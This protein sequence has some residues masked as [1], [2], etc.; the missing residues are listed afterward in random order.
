VA[1]IEYTNFQVL[2]SKSDGDIWVVKVDIST[3][4]NND[5]IA[6]LR[7]KLYALFPEYGIR[8][9]LMAWEDFPSCLKPRFS[10]ENELLKAIYTNRIFRGEWGVANH[11][12]TAQWDSCD[13]I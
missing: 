5:E 2:E 4:V 3:L 6:I 1:N 9:V 13:I 12:R 10:G 8:V 11:F 7:R